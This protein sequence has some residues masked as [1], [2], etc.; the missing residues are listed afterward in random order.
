MHIYNGHMVK[1]CKM[2]MNNVHI[3]YLKCT[4]IGI[5]KTTVLRVMSSNVAVSF[6]HDTLHRVVGHV[7]VLR[8]LQYGFR[9]DVC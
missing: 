3:M 6:C 8:S 9:E 4:S 2:F 1:L 5:G 7:A